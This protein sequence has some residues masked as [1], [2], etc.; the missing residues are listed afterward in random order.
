M[1]KRAKPRESPA[2]TGLLSLLEQLPRASSSRGRAFE[3]LAKWFFENDPVFQAQLKRV[4]LWDEW[5]GRWGPDAGIDLVAEDHAGELWAI[6]AKAYSPEYR[7]RK[8][9]VDTFL[10]ESAGSEFSFRLIIATTDRIGTTAQRTLNRQQLPVGTVLRSHLLE[11]RVA[12]PSSLDH[13]RPSPRRPK[14]PRQH[15]HRAVRDVVKGLAAHDRGHLVMA[16]GTGKTLTSLFI[17][18]ALDSRRIVF[19]VPSLS[20]LSQV[21]SEWTASSSAPLDFI[22]VCSDESVV[23]E[24]ELVSFTSDLAFPVTTDPQVIARHLRSRAPGRKVVFS[25][26]QSAGRVTEAQRLPGVPAFDLVVADEAHRLVGRPRGG[27][28][29]PL[30]EEEIRAKKRL[31]MTATPRRFTGRVVTVARERDLEIAS[32][33][34]E[35][36]F[37]PRLHTLTFG[38]AIAQGLL[39]DYQVAIIGIDDH[40]YRDWAE[41]GIL[42]R[43]EGLGDID[44]R[45]LAT[46]IGYAK[47]VRRFDIRRAIS[48]H[49]RVKGAREFAK[50]HKEVVRWM[51]V[52][53]RPG[54]ILHAD[55][56]SGDM[57]AGERRIKLE[58]LREPPGDRALLSNARCLTEG[59]DV[60]ALDGVAFID[61]RRSDVDVVQAVGRAIRLS[62]EKTIGTIVIPVFVG[63]E[64]DP[65][66]MLANSVFRPVWDVLNA[67]RS[68]DDDLALELDSL[69]QSVGKR[70]TATVALPRKIHIDLP[71]WIDSEFSRAVR[72]QLLEQTTATWEQW[73][74]LLTAFVEREGHAKVPVDQ[75]ELNQP[76]GK[77]IARQR[78]LRAAGELHPDRAERLELLPGWIWNVRVDDWE[79]GFDVLLR[80]LAREGH[81][82][83]KADHLENGY[84][85]G[86]WVVTVRRSEDRIS[87][88]RRQRLE[89]LPG[90]TW[91][92]GQ[93]DWDAAYSLLVTFAAREGHARVG[94]DHEE[95]GFALGRWT[96]RQ[97]RQRETMPIDRSERLEA[98]VG[99]SWDPGTDDWEHGFRL[100]LNYVAREGDALV[101]QSHREE[102]FP[103]GTWVSVRRTNRDVSDP[104]RNRR[105]EE[106]RGWSWSPVNDRWERAYEA[107]R[108]FAAREGHARVP[109][110]SREGNFSLG[111]WVV[112]QRT[113]R[114]DMDLDRKRRLEEVPGWTWTPLDDEWERGYALLLDYLAR[115]GDAKV[116][117][118]HMEGNYPLGQWVTVQRA[119]RAK[120]SEGR[121]S[122]LEQVPGWAWRIRNS[123]RSR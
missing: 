123:S 1:P 18:E 11:S 37:G 71:R 8:E 67:L 32:M 34:D 15:Q 118:A 114:D 52:R 29:T 103:L 43:G 120:M 36:L 69:R 97:R 39:T 14:R 17:T 65:E 59:I 68:H 88:G 3:R 73:F 4:W 107:L 75:I 6:Q 84:P 26:Y 77:W 116:P 44:A 27:F 106:L 23:D 79:R 95:E 86:R 119:R 48:F 12:W 64:G 42:V 22:A 83:V 51:P 96:V 2:P 13:L 5:P 80:F 31:F 9:D 47:A 72:V 121:I 109:V 101:P 62:T 78:R 55:F 82:R 108:L 92:P 63:A 30:R 33:D 56:I 58:A 16:C 66:Y 111:R 45:T 57:S 7:I 115:E 94:Q 91:D 113:H 60:P 38:Q 28:S 104:D 112:K 85:L 21:I 46:H 105:L 102:G 81:T 49:G 40:V 41:Q 87:P 53:Q 19:L 24:D 61:P 25:T 117:A 35:R 70:P 99:W 93:D 98:V 90:W 74:G 122:R 54:G 10:S 50:S 110:N 100:L 20:L 76:L 89:V